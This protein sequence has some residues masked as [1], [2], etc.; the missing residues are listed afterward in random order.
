MKHRRATEEVAL[1]FVM[2]SLPF[3]AIPAIILPYRQRLRDL[4]TQ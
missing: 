4:E 2:H 3:K 1:L